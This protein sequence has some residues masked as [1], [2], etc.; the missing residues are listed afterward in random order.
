MTLKIGNLQHFAAAIEEG[1]IGKAARRLNVS[2]PAITRSIRQLEDHL[3]V[4]LLERGS[5]GVGA[6]SF[7][8]S[9]YTRAKSI[10][11]DIRRAELEIDELRGGMENMLTVGALPSQANF[12]LPEATI[13]FAEI[14]P[15]TRV[16]VMQK[17]RAEILP[18][19]IRGEFDLI[20][21][22]LDQPETNDRIGQR[23][24]F[25]DRPSIVVRK[26]HPVLSE[27]SKIA[28]RL[29]DYPWV[30]PRPDADHRVYVNTYYRSLGLPI[31]NVV[32][33]CQTTPYLKSLV[34]QSDYVGVVPTNL[35]SIEEQAGFITAVEL[36]GLEMSITF[37]I[38]YSNERPVSSATRQFIKEI[39][40]ICHARRDEF[41]PRVSIQ[42]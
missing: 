17:G 20:F 26:D 28:E 11:S 4:P 9:L 6:T 24:L 38:Q 1:S 18:G 25:Y 42:I 33:E 41:E 13:R 5:K 19:L 30:T 36:E 29:L 34:M 2:Q 3:Q 7:G 22:F 40:A 31:P 21:A 8:E 35:P 12:I 16:R 15:T 10:L 23:L 39:E 32:V 37:G 27:G 14:R